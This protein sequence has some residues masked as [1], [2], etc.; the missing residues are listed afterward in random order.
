MR[1]EP[2]AGGCF[3]LTLLPDPGPGGKLDP[4]LEGR[5]DETDKAAIFAGIQG[6]VGCPAVGGGCD[7]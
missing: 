3:Q 5:D 2:E 4:E 1:D 7:A 6:T